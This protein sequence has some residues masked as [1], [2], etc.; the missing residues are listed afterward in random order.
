MPEANE[1]N[2]GIGL[3]WTVEYGKWLTETHQF[4]ILDRENNNNW[5]EIYY[6]IKYASQSQFITK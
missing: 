5:N 4:N 2:V 3:N 1:I 6:N